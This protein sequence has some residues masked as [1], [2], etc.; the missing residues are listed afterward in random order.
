M[1]Q[2]FQAL[3]R[4]GYDQNAGSEINSTDFMPKAQPLHSMTVTH[5]EYGR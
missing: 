4:Q 3:D 2:E 1:L 5:L